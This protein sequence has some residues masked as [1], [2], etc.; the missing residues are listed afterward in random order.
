MIIQNFEKLASSALRRQ[1][2]QIAEAGLS[3]INTQKAFEKNFVYDAGRDRLA[4]LGK[5]MI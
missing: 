3:A 2:L 1:A 4:V 5:S